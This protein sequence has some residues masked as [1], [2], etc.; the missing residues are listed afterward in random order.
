MTYETT[1]GTIDA[2]C[3]FD[4]DGDQLCI[5]GAPALDGTSCGDCFEA[6]WTRP[7][8]PMVELLDEPH[9]PAR[10]V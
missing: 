9:D 10:G 4:D 8:D 7:A 3:P 6:R 2:D 5:C 1:F